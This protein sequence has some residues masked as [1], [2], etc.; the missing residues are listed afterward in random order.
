MR[1]DKSANEPSSI[2]ARA[3]ALWRSRPSRFL[4]VFIVSLI[5]VI[6]LK[7]ATLIET[8][9]AQ[10]AP[11]AP[12]AGASAPPSEGA[13]PA[14]AKQPSRPYRPVSNWNDRPPPP[15]MCRPDPLSEAGENKILL[16]LKD[17]EAALATRAAALEQEQQQLDATKAALQKQV[18]ALKPLAARL[19]AM[20]TAHQSADD[21]KWASL[22]AT[23]GA[24]DPRS[25]ARIFDGL[26]PTIVFH[27]LQ[28][29]NS[30]KSAA[31]L[32]GMSP[33]TAEAITER[34]AGSPARTIQPANA[35]LPDAA[36]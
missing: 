35:L 27:V 33:A 36:P 34:L 16:H 15:P 7:T 3:L 2:L 5:A 30:R 24:M 32:A 12:S 31:I 6:A 18:A 26:D 17:R 25:A 9:F 19:E 20:N 8:A 1:R 13:A 22:V 11:A 10:A 21:A 29:M 4:P 28:R 14:S 23:Y